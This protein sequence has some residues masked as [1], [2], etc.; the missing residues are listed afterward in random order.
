[1]NL[2]SG[3]PTANPP[4]V[5]RRENGG[6]TVLFNSDIGKSHGLDPVSPFFWK[7]LDGRYDAASILGAMREECEGCIP[8]TA[9]EHLRHFLADLEKR[10]L[11]AV[12]C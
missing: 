3:C 7:M 11:I 8:D 10:G 2:Q 12:E 9:P 4:V 6:R 5:F 1:M